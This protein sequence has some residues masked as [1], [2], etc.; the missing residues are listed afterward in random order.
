[1]TTLEKL[2]AH[3]GWEDDDWNAAYSDRRKV[4][5]AEIAEYIT[6]LLVPPNHGPMNLY[7][8]LVAEEIMAC[9]ESMSRIDGDEI[10][11]EIAATDSVT[12]NPVPLTI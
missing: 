6:D 10:S 3:L 1:M 4:K 2:F 11:G 7:A 9:A 8:D 5:V 12:G